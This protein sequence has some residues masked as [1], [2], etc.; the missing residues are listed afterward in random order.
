MCSKLVASISSFGKITFVKAILL[1]AL[2]GCTNGG[3]SP[4]GE[5]LESNIEL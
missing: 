3:Y 5:S 1:M 4:I 2:A